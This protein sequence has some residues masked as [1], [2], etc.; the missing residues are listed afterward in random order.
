MKNILLDFWH[1]IKKPKDEQYSGT[2]KKYKWKVLF[3]L[4]GFNILFTIPFSGLVLFINEFYPL[5]HKFDDLDYN[6]ITLFLIAVITQPFLEEVVFRLGLRRKGFLMDLFS[7]E[8]WNRYFSKFVYLSV[9]TF[10]LAHGN[11]YKFDGYFF[12]LLIPFLTLSQFVTGFINTFLRV[13]FNFWMGFAFHAF[14]NFS[15]IVFSNPEMFTISKKVE[16]K[17]DRFQLEIKQ[18]VLNLDDKTIL[19]SLNHDTIYQLESSKF[20]AKEILE[21]MEVSENKYQILIKDFDIRFN[22]KKGI[23]KDSLLNILETEGYI[24]KK[25]PTN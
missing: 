21:T 4:L 22:S 8:K 13:R 16:M 10:A 18:P 15:A 9:I 24:V 14:W 20:S 11:N 23:H 25:T 6:P 3:T 12:I 19:Y 17:N 7:E 2:D 5:K 1:F